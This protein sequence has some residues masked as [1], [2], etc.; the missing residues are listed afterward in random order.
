MELTDGPI[1]LVAVPG[2]RDAINI[3]TFDYMEGR[4][5][6][7]ARKGK[8]GAV[9][10]SSFSRLPRR[11]AR[12]CVHGH[13]YVHFRTHSNIL[14][15]FHRFDLLTTLPRQ[16]EKRIQKKLGLHHGT[17]VNNS[18]KN[19][20]CVYIFM[21]ILD[22]IFFIKNFFIKTFSLPRYFIPIR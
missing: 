21:L 11:L 1:P 6:R 8:R 15:S 9:S 2:I 16:R 12:D 10:L 18:L 5:T 20:I 3:I 14:P 13:V 22:F 19:V 4:K 7:G 17:S